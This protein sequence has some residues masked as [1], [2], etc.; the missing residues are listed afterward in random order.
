MDN[1]PL[2]INLQFNR[3]NFEELYFKNKEGNFFF[4]PRTKR[5][6]ISTIII[7][8]CLIFSKSNT[9][10][11]IDHSVLFYI[12]IFAEVFFVISWIWEILKILKWKKSIKNYLDNIATHK[13]FKLIADDNTFTI[14]LDNDITKE[15]WNQLKACQVKPDYISIK[16]NYYYLL[17]KK[18]MTAE[19]YEQLKKVLAEKVGL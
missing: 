6:M 19:E 16:S 5:Y 11:V 17:P 4:G 18:S 15:Q 13:N 9:T 7:A 1:L 12:L 3:K 10:S 14:A 2:I 8:V